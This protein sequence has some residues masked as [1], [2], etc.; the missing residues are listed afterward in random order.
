MMF[1]GPQKI[2]LFVT[3]VAMGLLLL[4]LAACD[5][6]PREDFSNVPKRKEPQVNLIQHAHV[7]AFDKGSDKLQ[8]I[9]QEKLDSFLSKIGIDDS[10][11][12][13][14]VNGVP[15]P[16]GGQQNSHE[17]RKQR[18]AIVK[19]YLDYK[20]VKV[21]QLASR[22]GVSPVS[23]NKVQVLVRRYVVTLPGCPDWSRKPGYDYYNRV[24]SNWGCATATNF[25]LM[26]ANPGDLVSGRKLDPADGSY[27]S[28]F[29]DRYRK[30]E[31]VPLPINGESLGREIKQSG[32]GSSGSSSGS[33]SGSGS[34][35]G[36]GGALGGG[37][38]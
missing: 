25:G 14:V 9:E 2:Q 23:S 24:G 20:R 13:H 28:F 1:S 38:Q 5:G 3:G 18:L 15:K 19:A 12:V 17:L 30:G 31:K 4:L 22:F 32:S 36:L 34:G 8:S 7:V 16:D 29:I 35:E 26:V 11:T 27:A 10:D 37:S 33:G 6:F 21:S